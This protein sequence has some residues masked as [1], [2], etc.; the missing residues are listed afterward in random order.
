MAALNRLYGTKAVRVYTHFRLGRAREDPG[1]YA[2]QLCK[3]IG[4]GPLDPAASYR[5]LS[6]AIDDHCCVP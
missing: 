4:T 6:H 1:K 2:C 5:M 3:V